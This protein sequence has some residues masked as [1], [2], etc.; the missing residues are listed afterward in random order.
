MICLVLLSGGPIEASQK[1]TPTVLVGDG[2]TTLFAF[3]DVS[4]PFAYNLYLSMHQPRKHP[5]NPVLPLGEP[6]D[7]DEWQQ[8]YEGIYIGLPNHFEASGLAPNRNQE[9]V[10]SVKLATSRD[11]RRWV[12]VG[13]RES[14]IPVS[15]IGGGAI[16]TGQVW[17]G[18]RPQIHGDEL[19]FYYTGYNHRFET[20]DPYRSGVHLAKLKRDRFTSFGSDQEG[21]FVET[22]AIRFDGSRLFLNANASEGEVRVEVID[23]KGRKVLEGWTR[24]EANPIKGDQLRVE[25]K[26]RGQKDLSSFQGESIRFRFRLYNARLF[27]FWIE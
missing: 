14:F 20:K 7:P 3:D 4:I 26:W 5:D 24:D 12:K 15:E 16:D 1:V 22:R 9:G 23:L 17:A 11:L 27:S 10:N 25:A 13:N 6:G 2:E 21:G 18:S 8:R 19:W